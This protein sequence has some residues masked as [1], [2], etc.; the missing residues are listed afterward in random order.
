MAK[1]K[2]RAIDEE[3]VKRDPRFLELRGV[4]LVLLAIL[5]IGKYGFI[6]KLVSA[7]AIFLVG[8]GY[9]ILLIFLGVLGIY[10]IIKREKPKF[11]SSK[12][13][14]L[15]LVVIG[16]IIFTNLNYVELN[17]GQTQWIFQATLN[18]LMI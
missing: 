17:S 11:A 15:Y 4:I 18:D 6:G 13:V 10:Y 14:G 8:V 2:K 7:F 1:N 16:I 3:E 5:G 9:N 12:F